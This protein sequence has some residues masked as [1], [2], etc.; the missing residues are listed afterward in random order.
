MRE[1]RRCPHRVSLAVCPTLL[2]VG[3]Y[4][5]FLTSEDQGQ[6]LTGLE[7]LGS[8]V[9]PDPRALE[10]PKLGGAGSKKKTDM[11]PQKMIK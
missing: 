11:D 9:D 4:L 10:L 5:Y 6:N 7:I 1:N 3:R 8:R 2:Y